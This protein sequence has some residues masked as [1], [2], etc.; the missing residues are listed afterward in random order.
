MSMKYQTI[1]VGDIALDGSAA[2]RFSFSFEPD[3]DDLADSIRDVGLVR[4]PVL[5]RN[6]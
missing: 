3:I 6:A 4:P 1:R 5:R 2:G